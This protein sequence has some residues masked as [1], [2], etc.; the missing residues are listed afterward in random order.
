MSI[1][2]LEKINKNI[3]KFNSSK[4]FDSSIDFFKSLNYPM[5]TIQEE[6]NYSLDEFWEITGAEKNPYLK[7]EEIEK[8][9]ILFNLSED[10]MARLV[11]YSNYECQYY[12]NYDEYSIV[13][14]QM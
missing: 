1:D 9:E 14:K 8:I 5:D 4:L 10:E 12:S 3:K 7:N 6:S 13:K 2:I 11:S